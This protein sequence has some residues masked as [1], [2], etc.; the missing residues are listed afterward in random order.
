MAFQPM[1]LQT[2]EGSLYQL[3]FKNL[4]DTADLRFSSQHPDIH[5]PM[6]LLK[7]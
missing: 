2:K 1:Y 5:S 6:S 4:Q 7:Q 3:N